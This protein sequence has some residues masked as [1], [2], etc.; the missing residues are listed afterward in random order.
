MGSQSATARSPLLTSP[1][2]QLCGGLLGHTLPP[3]ITVGGE[4]HVGEDGVPLHG[5]HGRLVAMVVGAGG[6][7]EEAG[8]GVDGTEL[9]VLADVHPGNV[10]TD[11]AHLPAGKGRDKHGQVGLAAGAGETGSHIVGLAL[12]G[13]EAQDETVLGHPALRAPLVRCNPQCVTLLAQESIPPVP[14]AVGNHCGLLREVRDVLCVAAWPCHVLVALGQRVAHCVHTV[15]EVTRANGFKHLI[16]DTRH[17]VHVCSGVGR[18]RDLHA[19]F[20]KGGPQGPH[21]VGDDVH[22]AA[23]HAPIQEGFECFVHLLGVGPVVGRPGILLV[24]RANKSATLHTRHVTRV[25]AGQ[26]GV[27]PL[28]GVQADEGAGSHHEFTERFVLLLA[29]ITPVNGLR[30]TLCAH[31]IHPCK[32]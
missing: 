13:R 4:C 22:G 28:V 15:Q 5:A 31:F 17:D 10:V 21:A 19:I 24:A 12:G 9:A 7:T 27:G 29:P 8:L 26:K 30:A 3:H 20:G 2:N 16:A 6:D 32:Q 14:A 1:V 18:V 23:H 25:R 11:T